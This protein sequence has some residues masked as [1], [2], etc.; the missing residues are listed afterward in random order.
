MLFISSRDV[1]KKNDGGDMVTNSNYIFFCKL[2]GSEN[3]EVM[4][5]CLDIR[6]DLLSRIANR[7]NQVY[8]FY[9]GLTRRKLN[10]ILDTSTKYDYIFLETSIYGVIAYFLK[11]VKYMG[12]IITYFHNV[13]YNIERQTAKIRPQGFLKIFVIN[14]NERMA[15]KYSDTVIALS[16][17][18][19]NELMKHY[20][21]ENIRQ[22]PLSLPDSYGNCAPLNEFTSIPPTLLFI[23]SNWYPNI[24]GLDWFIRNVLD[25]VNIKLQIVGSGMDVLKDKFE[26]SKIEFLGFV[27]DLS[28]VL[29]EA[30][31]V[32]SPIFAGGGMKV[33]TCESLMYGKNIIG[34]A[35]A[36]S[37]YDLDIQQVGAK[38]ETKEEFIEF[39]SNQCSIKRRK[40]NYYCRQ[41]YLDRYSF[42]A[43]LIKY[44]ELLLN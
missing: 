23:G 20:K 26:H 44:K 41:V 21:A 38:C 7:I 28:S 36:F 6:R 14:F 39:L 29:V 9:R 2:L 19:S 27:P 24:Q 8:G 5:L 30:D 15:C 10:Y 4:N 17:R 37:G 18:D 43:I 34:T 3:V 1:N 31:F 35:E 11:R 42:D 12:K 13:E 32:I 40:F 33:K 25:H 22:I 16:K